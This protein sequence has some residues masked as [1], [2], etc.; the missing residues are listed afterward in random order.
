MTVS[1]YA[2]GADLNRMDEYAHDTR[3]S[4]F[5]TN[6]SL[7]KKQGIKDYPSFARQVLRASNAK[8]VSFE[9][10]ADDF[11]T[12]EVQAR[13]IAGWGKNV[14][15]KIPITNTKGESSIPLIERLQYDSIKV[16]VT[17]VFTM[18][19]IDL[20]RAV[21]REGIISI[22]AGRIADTGRDP[23]FT[24][25]YAKEYNKV[26]EVKI[27]WASAREVFNVYQAEQAG[28]DIVTITPDLIAK[29]ELHGKDLTQYSLETVQMFFRD[30]EGVAL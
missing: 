18:R 13:A 15:V 17:A 3:I 2:D 21:M 16:N 29:L 12:M 26:P 27:L 24:V 7:M 4:G 9:V 20:A 6:P 11:E 30:G 1:I 22:F 28:A 8:P 25:K 23:M 14:Y 19:Q 5:T 10:L